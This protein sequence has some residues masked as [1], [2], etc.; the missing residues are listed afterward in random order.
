MSLETRTIPKKT[1]AYGIKE[2]VPMPHL[3]FACRIFCG[4]ASLWEGRTILARKANHQRSSP[5]GSSSYH[6]INLVRHLH[7]SNSFPSSKSMPQAKDWEKQWNGTPEREWEGLYN[8]ERGS[9]F[10]PGGLGLLRASWFLC[11][12]VFSV[13]LSLFGI[14]E[15]YLGVY[16]WAPKGSAFCMGTAW[17]YNKSLDLPG[18]PCSVISRIC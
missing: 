6:F 15:A 17:S 3:R 4:L 12:F 7:S 18:V 14:L 9:E 13:S 11:R 5:S 1:S 16:F 8:S 10:F 2:G